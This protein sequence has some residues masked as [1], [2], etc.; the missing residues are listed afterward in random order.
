MTND[1]D[2]GCVLQDFSID[3]V[4]SDE[5][6]SQLDLQFLQLLQS[7]SATHF[8]LLQQ[9]RLSGTADKSKYSQFIVDIAPLLEDFIVKLFAVEPEYQDLCSLIMRDQPLWQF[10]HYFIKRCAKRQFNH[11]PT[12]KEWHVL[13][14][15]LLKQVNYESFT[16]DCEHAVAT[17]A[18]QF[19]QQPDSAEHAKIV[20]WC[21]GAMLLVDAQHILHNWLS[22][23][24]P[25][26]LD[27]QHLIK[28]TEVNKDITVVSSPNDLLK[29]RD[30]F[31]LTDKGMSF[32]AVSK[33][34]DYC[35]YCHEK[36]DDFCS[37]GFPVK[38]NTDQGVRDNVLGVALRGCPLDEKISEMNMLRDSG[39]VIA[40]LAAVTIDNPLCALTGHRICNDCMLSCI[41]QKQ[42]P[43]NIPQIESSVLSDILQLPYGVE[44]YLLL[45]RWNPLRLRQWLPQP[46]TGKSVAIM[47]TGPAG[48]AMAHHLLMEGCAVVAMDGL[49]IEPL[50]ST[51]IDSS[52]KDYQLIRQ[53]LSERTIYGFGGV[54]EY[55][56]TPRWDKNFLLL[57]YISLARRKFFRIIG[58]VRFG[59]NFLI[60]DATKF[61][62][63]HVCLAVGAGLPRELPILNSLAPGMRQANEFLMYL[64]LTGAYRDSSLLNLDVRLPAV[65][66]GG[67]LTAIDTATE[68]QAYYIKQVEQLLQ[69]Y[70][71]LLEYYSKEQL[72]KRCDDATWSAWKLYCLHGSMV[73][74]ERRLAY[75]E[76][77]DPCFIDLIRNWGGVTIIYRKHM[78]D[79]PA[80]KRNYEEIQHALAEGILY[81]ECWQPTKV[82]L[83]EF[84]HCSGL[85]CNKTNYDSEVWLELDNEHEFSAKA[86][87]VATGAKPNIA[88]AYEHHDELQYHQGVY[89]RYRLN[90][91]HSLT[92]SSDIEPNNSTAIFTNYHENDLHV[93]V[94]GDTNPAYQGS[95]VNALASAAQHY[96]DVMHDLSRLPS[97]YSSESIS[98]HLNQLC[99]SYQAKITCLNELSEDLIELTV[100]APQVYRHLKSG[101]FCRVQQ[102]DRDIQRIDN[103]LL[104]TDALALLAEKI[105]DVSDHIRFIVKR[106]NVSSHLVSQWQVGQQLALM[107]PTGAHFKPRIE[108]G[109]LLVVGDV[110]AYQ[111]LRS[112]VPEWLSQSTTIDFI[113]MFEKPQLWQKSIADLPL[114]KLI[115]M[116]NS[117]GKSQAQS[118]DIFYGD[119]FEQWQTTARDRIES[120]FCAATDI[121]IVMQPCDLKRFGL[122]YHSIKDRLQNNHKIHAAVYNSMQ[123][124]LK[125]VCAQ[126]LQWQIDPKTQ[127]RTKAVYA[128]SWQHQPFDIIDLDNFGERLNQNAVHEQISQLWL[129]YL[130]DTY[131][132]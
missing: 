58:Q 42:Q 35:V 82:V 39:Y 129:D 65:V 110:N 34:A 29:P 10:H 87:F 117:A 11:P 127:Q 86:I 71:I 16:L 116:Y 9:W 88:Y 19:Q 55:G 91:Q 18:L 113:A 5:Q 44:I 102:Y 90:N 46:F 25:N 73:A 43:V 53:N 128:C 3:G 57:I 72:I 75:Q 50:N 80:Y 22:I 76:N 94:I 30:G 95:V 38:K 78:Y 6:L 98:D 105:P 67:G 108:E 54:S 132:I 126:C 48:I 85:I 83:D 96:H 99:R 125:G 61:G 56:I 84:G 70:E 60:S 21:V 14:E 131:N 123:C 51:F 111:L 59:G 107:G 118:E 66:I 120:L 81:A 89:T 64:Q 41:Y 8:Q 15:W 79:S 26:K 68:V 97:M 17:Y 109:R 36:D 106:Q 115:Y 92:E 93:S 69:R 7:Y 28:T 52:I 122:Y 62:F 104:T 13:S 1:N 101:Q 121:I 112:L 77:R 124:M 12:L 4:I 63:Q 74:Q 45:I 23:Q 100:L 40:A 32:T 130:A 33:Q 24:L 20:T 49:K 31:N 27:Y 114:N 47:G 37:T 2:S 103:T 119:W